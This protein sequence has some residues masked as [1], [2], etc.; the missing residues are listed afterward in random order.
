MQLLNDHPLTSVRI[1]VVT[2]TFVA[3]GVPEGIHD[4][5]RFLEA[6]N[7]A[8]TARHIEL[9]DPAIRPLYRAAA[10][11][12]LE[13]PILVRRDDI[14]FANFEGPHFT[15]GTAKPTVMGAPVLLMAP[16]FQI[17]G[18][19]DVAPGA[20]ATQALRQAAHGFFVVRNAT[21]YDAEGNTLGEGEQI[22]VNGATVQMT[23]ASRRHIDLTTPAVRRTAAP[24]AQAEPEQ[25]IEHEVVRA[26]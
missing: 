24:V 18:S 26:A 15:R 1:E 13:A 9:H 14:V 3:S 22:I 17:S 23:A 6:L 12:H 21:V 10:Q 4:L 7:N 11:L 2:T 20:D 5:G 8:A 19:F 16:P 25:H